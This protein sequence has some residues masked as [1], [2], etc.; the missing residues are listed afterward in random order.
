M[1]ITLPDDELW[2]FVSQ[3]RTGMLS[4]LRR[5]GWPVTLPVW[6]VVLDELVYVP[7]FA[8]LKKV[9]R[10]QRDPRASFL[11]ESGEV[12]TELRAVTMSVT[13]A[14]VIGGERF[15]AATAALDVKYPAGVA[16]PYDRMP[17]AAQKYYGE[18]RVVL[19]LTPTGAPISWDNARLRLAPVES[20]QLHAHQDR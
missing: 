10:L 17:A 14:V 19:E 9:T 6:F 4:T 16:A 12:W 7:S 18:S 2:Q 1:A 13:G 15:D 5:D 20:Q 11:I 3:A 8:G